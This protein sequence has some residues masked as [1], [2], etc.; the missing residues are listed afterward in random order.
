MVAYVAAA[1]S[2]IKTVLQRHTIF[3]GGADLTAIGW[4]YG[5]HELQQKRGLYR[6]MRAAS[7]LVWRAESTLK[8]RESILEKHL[9]I[10]HS[11]RQYPR[12]DITRY[13]HQ[14]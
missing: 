11:D 14:A 7:Y 9:Y 10:F 12:I 5:S 6:G 3:G 4:S 1:W 13:T 8:M 2:Y